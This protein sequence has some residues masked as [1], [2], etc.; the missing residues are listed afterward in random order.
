MR[1]V[2]T[3]HM[4]RLRRNARHLVALGSSL[5]IVGLALSLEVPSSGASPSRARYHAV[6]ASQAKRGGTLYMVGTGDVDYMDP[7]IDFGTVTNLALRMYTQPLMSYPAVAGKTTTLVPDLAKAVPTV[8]T[9]GLDYTFTIRKGVMWD[10]KP[11]RQVTAADI[12]RGVE[13]SCNPYKPSA[14]L[15]EYETLVVGLA[16]FCKGFAKV[17]PT[18]SAMSRYMNSHSVSGIVL[19]AKN[20]LRVTFKL[21]HKAVYFPAMTAG[22]PGFYGAPVEYEKYLPTS[23]ALAHHL[24]SDGPYSVASYNP[25]KS[26]VFDRNPAWKASLDPLSKA[27]VN[28]IV[29]TETVTPSTALEELKAGTAHADMMWGTT[30]VPT[31]NIP[32][33]VASR[34]P[35]FQLDPTGG[36]TPFLLF[37]FADPNNGGALK[38]LKVRQAI[39][40]AINR[41]ALIKD[42]G[43]PKVAPPMTQVLPPATL[44]TIKGKNFN[45][46]PYNPTKAKKV[47]E[48]RHLHIKLLYMAGD[49]V[50]TKIFETIQFELSQVGVSVSGLAVP[51]ATYFTKY[52]LAPSVAKR[53]VWDMAMDAEFPT[54]Y[55][56]NAFDFIFS[57][58]DTAAEAPVG[59]NLELY[60]NKALDKIIS[61]AVTAGSVAA[62]DKLWYQADK[63]V[64]QQAVMYP[65]EE[66]DYA[67]YHSSRVHNAVFLPAIE[68]F[69]PTNVWLSS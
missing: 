38:T 6:A 29:V 48:P 3:M 31:E 28:K 17:A 36:E 61:E 20:P 14:A 25:G 66:A 9:T 30:E 22:F 39:E 32:Q 10:T 27:Y 16:T 67:I 11:P 33:L 51:L 50:Q 8:S 57:V 52:L 23:L 24:I 34:T 58:Y 65:I 55:G 1:N 44:R 54:W 41:N 56:D 4:R 35:N 46:Y 15:S 53:G 19:N 18:V 62:A 60:S 64:M 49:P 40:T 43:G 26:I 2:T 7:N 37:N 68:E 47:L 13:R 63:F 69:D 12:L 42:S 21:A 5:A 45:L 59:A